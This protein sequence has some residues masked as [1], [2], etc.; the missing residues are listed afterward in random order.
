MHPEHIQATEGDSKSQTWRDSVTGKQGPHTLSQ[1]TKPGKVEH[2]E[3]VFEAN[4][5]EPGIVKPIMLAIQETET[6]K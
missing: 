6:E 3:E 5:N 2:G 4:E 1:E